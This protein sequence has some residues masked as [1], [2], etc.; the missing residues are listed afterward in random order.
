MWDLIVSVPDHCLSFYFVFSCQV[1]SSIS[2]SEY[3]ILSLGFANILKRSV[4]FVSA[5]DN[6]INQV[7]KESCLIIAKMSFFLASKSAGEFLSEVCNSLQQ[8]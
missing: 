3:S 5:A 6:D 7:G 8:V 1:I 2:F 4:H